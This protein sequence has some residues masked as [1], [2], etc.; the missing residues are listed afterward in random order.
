MAKTHFEKLEV[1]QKAET[2]SNIVWD[3]VLYWDGFAKHALGKQLVRST[4]SIVA[5]IAE[6][7]GREPTTDR[8]HFIHMVRGSLYETQN[9]LRRA[10]SRDLLTD[11]QT[12]TIKPLLN[13][14]AP[15]L[16]AYLRALRSRS[17][18]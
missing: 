13:A 2:L 14:L 8:C 3:I 4:D 17:K 15:M 18:N 9:W 7:I 6:S 1:Y 5:N 16:N 12:D 11:E 10:Y